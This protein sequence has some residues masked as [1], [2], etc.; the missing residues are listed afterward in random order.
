VGSASRKIAVEVWQEG[1]S[2]DLALNLRDYGVEQ[3]IK[4]QIVSGS[5]LPAPPPPLCFTARTA[6]SLSYILPPFLVLVTLNLDT[7]GHAYGDEWGGIRR[8]G[9][10]RFDALMVSAFCFRQTIK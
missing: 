6:L 4:L 10:Q 5:W 8:R 9:L 7:E 3:L 2:A 1:G